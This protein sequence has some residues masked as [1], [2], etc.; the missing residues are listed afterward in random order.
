MV[1]RLRAQLLRQKLIRRVVLVSTAVFGCAA[2]LQ[3][4]LKSKLLGIIAGEVIGQLGAQLAFNLPTFA[5]KVVGKLPGEESLAWTQPHLWELPQGLLI[6]LFCDALIVALI[7]LWL[8][9][10]IARPY[11]ALVS[12]VREAIR[13]R[14]NSPRAGL[15]SNN[16]IDILIEDLKDMLADSQV[17]DSKFRESHAQFEHTQLQML[18]T[19]APVA[20]LMCDM[21]QHII[22]CSNQWAIDFNLAQSDLRGQPLERALPFMPTQWQE[23]F[24]RALNGERVSVAEET[25]SRPNECALVIRWAVQSWYDAEGAPGGLIIA[26][27]RIDELVQAREDALKSAQLR[28]Q[29][30]AN[31]SHELRTPMNAVIGFA[32]LLYETPITAPQKEY[33]EAIQSSARV[34]LA[35]INDVLDFAKLESNKVV[36]ETLQFKLRDVLERSISILGIS[37]AQKGLTIETT[38]DDRV[39]QHLIGDPLR[40]QQILTNLISN[41]I[42]FTDKGK[43]EIFVSLQSK[44]EREVKLFFSVRDSGIGIAEGKLTLLFKAFSQADGSI[45]RR[46]GGT[47]L[48][49]AICA[50]LVELMGGTIGVASSVGEGSTFYF[51]GNFL[52][53]SAGEEI[54]TPRKEILPLRSPVI[55]SSSCSMNILV[56]EDNPVNQKLISILLTRAGHKVTIAENG[57]AAIERLAKSNFD[58]VILDLQMPEMGGIETVKAIREREKSSGARRIPVLALTAHAFEDDRKTCYEAGMDA[59][60]SK[61]IQRSELIT[62]IDR[63]STAEPS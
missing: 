9:R 62:T 6:L 39:P 45:T 35:L 50:E 32:E 25:I 57:K 43:I 54:G 7:A 60:L 22:A 26:S 4:Y 53:A 2:I 13:S 8:Q 34:Q 49:L 48:G 38:I 33:L 56:A 52:L 11:S 27:S 3:V 40:L 15:V 28:S 21:S 24:T 18:V 46:Y 51:T 37:S 31:V 5:Y 16:N 42:K 1:P 20:M 30:L 36:L 63:L 55:Q 41:A 12:A 10:S 29:F 19:H 17:R 61:P 44:S 47:G 23:K 58:I 14:S 59:Y